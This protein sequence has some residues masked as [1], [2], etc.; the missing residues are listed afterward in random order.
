MPVYMGLRKVLLYVSFF[1]F[2][3]H[4]VLFI[5]LFTYLFYIARRK[6]TFNLADDIL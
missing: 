3:F 1:G 6:I 4:C 2:L 5:Y